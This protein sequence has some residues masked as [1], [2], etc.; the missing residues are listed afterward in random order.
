MSLAIEAG[1]KA[2]LV[3]ADLDVE[4]AGGEVAV[5]EVGYHER[6]DGLP[7]GVYRFDGETLG[8]DVG[9]ASE[10]YAFLERF[11]STVLGLDL[12][13]IRKNPQA[14]VGSP[15]IELLDFSDNEGAIGPDTSRKLAHD[16]AQYGESLKHAASHVNE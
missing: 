1:S 7:E 9:G 13:S 11:S 4:V 2:T 14:Q 16:F 12:G 3:A 8:F 6:L 15:F 10:Y 5:Y